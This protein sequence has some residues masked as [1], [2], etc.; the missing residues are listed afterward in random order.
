MVKVIKDSEYKDIIKNNKKVVIDCYADWC[1][2]CRMLAPV[3]DALSEEYTEVNF[4]KVN[5]DSAENIVNE[6]EIMSIPT[7]LIFE[8]GKLKDKVI[9]LRSKSELEEI[10]K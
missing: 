3:V 2:P 4:Y 10:I 6:F 9:G 7:L 1:G 8:N 5:I